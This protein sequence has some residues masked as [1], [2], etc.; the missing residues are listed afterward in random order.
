MVRIGQIGLLDRLPGPAAWAGI[1]LGLLPPQ[2][3][4]PSAVS[5]QQTAT[6]IFLVFDTWILLY[7]FVDYS[8]RMLTLVSHDNP[9]VGQIA[10]CAAMI[11]A[12]RPPESSRAQT[13]RGGGRLVRAGPPVRLFLRASRPT[14]S[15]EGHGWARPTNTATSR[16]GYFNSATP[17]DFSDALGGLPFETNL[18]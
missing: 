14:G 2:E 7:E 5:A 18:A 13:E 15:P 10:S 3:A 1:G 11:A 16:G 6:P 17:A 9:P 8:A 12:Q 4:A